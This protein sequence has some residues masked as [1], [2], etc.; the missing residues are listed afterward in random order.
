MKPCGNRKWPDC[1][2]LNQRKV[3]TL[4][5]LEKMLSDGMLAEGAFIGQLMALTLPAIPE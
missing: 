1:G 3:M 4:S 2:L 5:R